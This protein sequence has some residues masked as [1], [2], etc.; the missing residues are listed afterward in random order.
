MCQISSKLTWKKIADKCC[1]Q[2]CCTTWRLFQSNVVADWSKCI[3]LLLEIY[4][5]LL[6]D[7]AF[8]TKELV[9]SYVRHAHS[10]DVILT[11]RCLLELLYVRHDTLL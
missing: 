9:R 3:F 2:L 1:C 10:L 4:G 7:I 6:N 11:V 5:V 8:I